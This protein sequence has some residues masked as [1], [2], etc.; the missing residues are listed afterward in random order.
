[1]GKR[2]MSE[3]KFCMKTAKLMQ[4]LYPTL[5]TLY[6]VDSSSSGDSSSSDGDSTLD[7]G[8]EDIAK[9][10]QVGKRA[11][12]KKLRNGNGEIKLTNTKVKPNDDI[13][14]ATPKASASNGNSFVQFKMDSLIILFL[15]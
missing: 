15:R 12:G 9:E 2:L 10:Q 3:A 11:K 1:M 7:S 8:T 13:R 14:L 5:Q 6:S 4:L